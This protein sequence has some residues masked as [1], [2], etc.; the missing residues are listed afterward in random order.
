MTARIYDPDA[1]R[2]IP[3][4]AI[5]PR[6]SRARKPARTSDQRPAWEVNQEGTEIRQV[7]CYGED[8]PDVYPDRYLAQQAAHGRRARRIAELRAEIKRLESW[9]ET[10]P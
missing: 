9:R 1:N 5:Q 7:E 10:G 3:K 2:E 6:T 4:Q 8:D